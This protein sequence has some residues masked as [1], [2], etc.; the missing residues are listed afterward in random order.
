M[1]ARRG[2]VASR[3]MTG[4]EASVMFGIVGERGMISSFCFLAGGGA[5]GAVAAAV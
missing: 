5:G 3:A 4:S 2:F 1:E